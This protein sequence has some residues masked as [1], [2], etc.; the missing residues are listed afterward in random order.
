MDLRLCLTVFASRCR[1]NATSNVRNRSFY[2]FVLWKT[3]FSGG[4]NT[5]RLVKMPKLHQSGLALLYGAIKYRVCVLGQHWAKIKAKAVS[6]RNEGGVLRLWTWILAILGHFLRGVF[7]IS[8][9][10]VGV[11]I[12]MFLWNNLNTLSPLQPKPLTQAT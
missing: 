6:M 11:N 8:P 10:S 4:I 5:T 2:L 3:S 9:E 1:N 7:P 12:Y